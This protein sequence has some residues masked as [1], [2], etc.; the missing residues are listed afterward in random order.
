VAHLPSVAALAAGLLLAACGGDTLETEATAPDVSPLYELAAVIPPEPSDM[1]ADGSAASAGQPPGRATLLD[2]PA[3]GAEPDNADSLRRRIQAAPVDGDRATASGSNPAATATA[4]ATY[5][6]VA[7][8]RAAYGLDKLPAA[9]SANKGAYQGS[10]Q[11]I[12]IVGAFHNPNI[13]N[14]LQVFS[15]K[16]GLPTCTVLAVAATAKLPLAK[17]AAGAGCSLAV[18]HATAAGGITTRAPAVNAGWK[19]E[20]SLDVEWAHAMAPMARIILVQAASAGSADLTGALTLAAKLGATVVNMSWGAGEF[21]GQ[22]SLDRYFQAAGVSYI[23]A[24]GDSGR[25]VS[26]PAV[27]P[28][29]LA[30]GGTT[31]AASG[32]ARSETAWAGSGGGI[33]AYNAAPAWQGGVKVTSTTGAVATAT[34]RVLPDVAFNANPS[35][36]QL[37][38]VTPASGTNGWLVAGG[39][40][41]GA[42]QWAG[43]V[44]VANAVRA[45]KGKAPLGML[46]TP[47]YR[48]IAANASLYAANLLDVKTGANGTCKGCSATTGYDLV[49]GLGTPH[50]ARLVDVLAG[51]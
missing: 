43:L 37:V 26:W 28:H 32:S 34:K 31:L 4:A 10:G 1:D 17:P 12:A 22:G 24:S 20:T 8:V 47:V 14:D 29:V 35:S 49:T 30:V 9:T 42:P 18:V 50:A 36:G 27:S 51:L 6:T 15:A 23:A 16:F 2:A 3:A 5:Y 41:I 19:T 7:Q 39:T 48:S 13:A 46:G 11:T 33:S 38:Y 25:G 45:G 44:A 40:S 21:S